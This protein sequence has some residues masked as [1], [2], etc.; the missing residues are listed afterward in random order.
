[1]F[2]PVVKLSY[3][4]WCSFLNLPNHYFYLLVINTG[5]VMVILNCVYI[6]IYKEIRRQQLCIQNLELAVSPGYPKQAQSVKVLLL[7]VG[8]FIISWWPLLA[9]TVTMMANEKYSTNSSAFWLLYTL[10]EILASTN[11][12]M[13]PIIYMFRMKSFQQEFRKKCQSLKN[14]IFPA[15]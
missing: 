13:N 3:G 8:C 1:M 9:C 14:Y 5:V 12:A 11:S 7:T 15:E 2:G 10:T 6:K 4:E